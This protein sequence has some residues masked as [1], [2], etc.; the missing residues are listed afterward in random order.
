M[1]AWP[2]VG[3]IGGSLGGLTAALV[4]RD[5]GCEIDVWERS[6]AELESRGAGIVVLDETLRYLRER[7][8]IRDDDVTIATSMLRYLDSDG[9]IVHERPQ[10]YRYSGWHTIYRSLLGSLDEARYH[11]GVEVSGFEAEGDGMR[12]AFGDGSSASVDLLV[13][14]DGIGSSARRRLVPDVTPAYAGYAAWRGTVA[15]ERMDG[16]TLAALA[17]AL[18]YQV[19]SAGHI[20]VYPIPNVDGATEPGRRLLNFVW[21]RNYPGAALDDLMTDRD[22]VRRDTTLP[23]GAVDP[24]HVDEMRAFA[25]SHLAPPLAAVVLGTDEPFV[26]AVFDIDVP[27]MAFGRTCLIGDA[28]FALRP[29]IA[30]GT[31]KAA[32]DGWALAEELE[33]AGGD[34]SVALGNWEARQLAVGRGALERSRRN[35]ERSQVLGTWRPEDPDLNYG[36]LGPR[37]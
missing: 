19:I 15:E 1:G 13:C 25:T 35:G 5:L 23:P 34:V 11:L 9:S 2:R 12:V 32:S 33:A 20:L 16:S 10:P 37:P 3:V 21:Y 29:H 4:L 18:V 6:T 8:S 30:A 26:Q 36:L 14:A 27:R 7:T 24:V 17:G 28:A 22:G 31:A